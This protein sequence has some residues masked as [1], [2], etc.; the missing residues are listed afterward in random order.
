MPEIVAWLRI[1]RLQFYPMTFI[2]YSIGS[3]AAHKKY[4]DWNLSSYLIGYLVMFFI[5]LATVLTNEYFDYRTDRINKN[6][7]LFTGGSRVLVE[8]LITLETA[9]K[10]IFMLLLLIVPA[11]YLLISTAPALPAAGIILIVF[12]GLLL[13]LGYTAPPV[14]LTYRGFG[15]ID[16]GITHSPYIILCGFFFQSGR[17]ADPL[18]YLLSIPLFFAVISS[19]I[20]AGVPDYVA[21]K[22]VNKKTLPVIF[23]PKAASYFALASLLLSAAGLILLRKKNILPAWTLFLFPLLL[24]HAGKFSYEILEFIHSRN[25]DRKIDTILK[26]GLSYI[27][28]FGA[29]PLLSLII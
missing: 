12:A 20:L 7:G 10:A 16:V 23:G 14:K 22:T 11:V 15:E 21:D 24:L 19:I 29:I 2:A 17:L 18:P 28:W 27:I 6:A 25:Y 5:E 9:R 3:A 13:G 26:L 8:G 4:G 1:A